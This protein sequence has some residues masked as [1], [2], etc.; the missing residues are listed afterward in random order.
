[1]IL[2]LSISVTL[3]ARLLSGIPTAEHVT[4]IAG[5]A[6]A[7]L[8]IIAIHAISMT[9]CCLYQGH[10]AWR[11]VETARIMDIMSVMMG[12]RIVE[13]DAQPRVR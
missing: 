4:L 12:I 1:M 9:S 7:H 8:N 13:M 2:I 10:I 6:S 5:L 3:I 11:D